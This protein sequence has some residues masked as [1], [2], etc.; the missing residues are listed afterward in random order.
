MKKSG[1]PNYLGSRIRRH[2]KIN[3]GYL[4]NECVDDRDQLTIS[5][6]EFGFPIGLD[7]NLTLSEV[8][9]Q[10]HTGARQFPNMIERYLQVET[11]EGACLGPFSDNPFKQR[12][13]LSPLNTVEKR[14]SEERR[15][16]LDLSHPKWGIS[17][18]SA[19]DT[20][21]I[22]QEYEMLKYPTV[23]ALVELVL[24]H[25][26]GCALFKRDLRRAYRQLPVDP[27][28]IHVLGYKW[29]G[30]MYFDTTLPMGLKSSAYFCQRVTNMIRHI[31]EKKQVDCVNY[32]DDFGGA[33]A[34]ATAQ[35]STNTM[36]EVIDRSGLEKSAAKDVDP[37]CIMIFLGILFNTLTLTL[38]IGHDRLQ[39][40][41]ALIQ[42]WM[43]K[44]KCSRRELQSLLGKLQ[45]VAACVRP[46]RVFTMRLLTLLRATPKSGSI[47]IPQDTKADLMWWRDFLV[48]YNGVSMMPQSVWSQPDEILATDACLDGCGGWFEGAFFH[49][50]FPQS[51]KQLK[52]H[53]N[54]L[55][56]LTIMVA[57]KLWA[58][59]L[60]GKQIT[61]L[62][63]NIASVIVLNK[64]GTRDAF[65]GSCLREIAYLA[66]TSDF[67]IRGRHIPGQD[68]RI[69]DLLSRWDSLL[70]PKE[71]LISMAGN[72]KLREETVSINLFNF[73]HNW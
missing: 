60:H 20:S 44:S 23:D 11:S 9:C 45:F 73:E 61:V 51:L 71:Q 24:K 58:K 4:R 50:S 17:V 53:I 10:N 21:L 59:F 48:C 8:T 12:Y 52:L 39:E 32:L 33:D 14:D 56:L 64:G 66:A 42:V 22:T 41:G 54:A 35:T 30:N 3:I 43:K 28:D 19:I 26:R 49:A 57:L 69:P 63:D 62:C 40:I 68:N 46:G 37:T 47:D 67:T 36:D 70:C 13:H 34:W 16:I 38:S 31:L 55:E 72:V 2:S 15:V 1:K 25:G 6:L 65:Q 27:G 5:M 29:D 7:P 18:N